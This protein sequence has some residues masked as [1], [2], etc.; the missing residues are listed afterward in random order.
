MQK[1]LTGA[2]R[3]N[4]HIGVHIVTWSYADKSIFISSVGIAKRCIPKRPHHQNPRVP[5]VRSVDFISYISAPVRSAS[6][7]AC[8][9]YITHA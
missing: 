5:S 8:F 6:S 9:F 2:A 7:Y 4:T 3:A 1:S